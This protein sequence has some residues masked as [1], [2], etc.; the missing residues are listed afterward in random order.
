MDSFE[1]LLQKFDATLLRHNM[2]AY[3]NL[4]PPLSD[5]E[6]DKGLKEIGIDDENVKALFQWKSGMENNRLCQMMDYG[7]LLSFDSIKYQ[8]SVNKYYDPR[9]VPLISDNGEEMLLFN[10]NPGPHYGKLYLFSVPQL[11]IDYPVSIYDS[12]PAM[13]ETTIELYDTGAFKYDRAENWLD[14]NFDEYYL[15]TKK[16]NKDC[17]FWTEHDEVIWKDWYQI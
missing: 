4:L 11:Y 15:I 16:H 2:A 8:I 7:G 17:V 9:L 5:Q 1:T 13:L 3:E 12:L 14:I 10:T 6:I